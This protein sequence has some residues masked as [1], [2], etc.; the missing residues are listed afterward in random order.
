MP[1]TPVELDELARFVMRDSPSMARATERANAVIPVI[2]AQ[3]DPAA[4]ELFGAMRLFLLG[5]AARGNGRIDR[6]DAHFEESVRRAER[7]NELRPSSEGFRVLADAHNQLLDIRGTAYKI[8]NAWKARENAVRAVELDERN[9]LAQL[10]AA[11]Y[12]VSAPPIAGGDLSRG[13]RHIAAARINGTASEYVRFLVAVWEGRLAAQ[14]GDR[15][16][17]QASLA[18][19]H[20]IYPNS[21]WLAEIAASLEVE[22]P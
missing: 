22:L 14:R 2:D 21:W 7:A 9:P 10:A 12:F 13:E 6:A 3:S 1:P 4:R 11:S 18:R 15:P 5:F 20:A 8:F 16:G 19:A 17:A